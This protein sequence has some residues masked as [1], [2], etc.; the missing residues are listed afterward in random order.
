ME[1]LKKQKTIWFW[2]ALLTSIL[3][4]VSIL[5]VVLS[6]INGMF[7]I[8]AF[9]IVLLVHGFYGCIFYWLAFAKRRS[10][11]RL[12][13]LITKENMLSV[14]L[15][16]VQMGKREIDIINSIKECIVKGYISGYYF[17]EV[18]RSLCEIVPV[19]KA[20]ECTSCGASVMTF[21][22]VGKCEYCGT[23]IT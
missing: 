23:N 8:M 22:G 12:L 16:S 18:K 14:S 9:S 10:L 1:K 5:V 13:T 7:L 3:A 6:A 11:M 17:D 2:V 20:V 4:V 15:L 21:D 19:T